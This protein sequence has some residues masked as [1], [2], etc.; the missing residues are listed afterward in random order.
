MDYRKTSITAAGDALTAIGQELQSQIY[1]VPLDGS[2][3][4]R[5]PSERFDGFQGLIQLRDAVWASSARPAIHGWALRRHQDPA[6][7]ESRRPGRADPVALA[8][9]HVYGA[10]E[11]A[12]AAP[13][14]CRATT[15]SRCSSHHGSGPCWSPLR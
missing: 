5:I 4:R 14:Q 9:T 10:L 3:L 12:G 11:G 6:T 1:V 13:R 7:A 8:M 2:P 15:A